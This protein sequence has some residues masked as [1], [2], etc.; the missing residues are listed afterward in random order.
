MNKTL[1]GK[2]G[3]L[4]L[5]ND[6]CNE[7]ESHCSEKIPNIKMHQFLNNYLLINNIYQKYT[8]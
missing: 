5:T 4:F 8:I 7:L 6:S 3:Y 2:N 1:I